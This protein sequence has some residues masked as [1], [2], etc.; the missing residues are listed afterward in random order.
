[1][2]T[3]PKLNFY[4]STATFCVVL[5]FSESI[6]PTQFAGQTRWNSGSLA[7]SVRP[8]PRKTAKYTRTTRHNTLHDRT[9]TRAQSIQHTGKSARQ[10]RGGHAGFSGIC[11]L[12]L[13]L[14][15]P[16]NGQEVSVGQF[17]ANGPDNLDHLISS[18]QSQGLKINRLSAVWQDKSIAI[19]TEDDDWGNSQGFLPTPN[20]TAGTSPWFAERQTSP[21]SNSRNGF[22]ITLEQ[23]AD[24]PKAANEHIESLQ[25]L[26]EDTPSLILSWQGEFAEQ[27]RYQVSAL[28]RKLDLKGVHDGVD[29]N[30]VAL[31][32]G[33]Q[34]GGGW[35]FGD[36]FAALRV[37]LG[38]GIDSL[39]LKGFGSDV[40]VSPS[41]EA[42]TLESISIL[43]SLS[44]SIDQ[45]SDIHLSLGR[46]ESRAG[47]AVTGIDTLDTIN[48]GY[49]WS[50]WPSTRIGVEVVGKDFEGTIG[51]ENSTEIKI[52]AQQ[53][54]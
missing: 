10:S 36:L 11:A 43:P 7:S 44:Y 51:D 47:E 21:D 1:M 34:V 13:L 35:Y 15:T 40:T 24:R 2:T 14:A 33:L 3:S 4:N 53:E 42:E 54:F 23:P 8:E 12:F 41:G 26:T 20:A 18:Y 38:D 17:G 16:A 52:G 46:Y 25:G 27:G 31:G 5:N 39:I 9:M 19:G 49:T 30:D 32:W 45:Y 22:S 50:P 37:T 48:L 29:V 28:G 6:T